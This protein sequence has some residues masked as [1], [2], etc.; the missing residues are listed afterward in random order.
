MMSPMKHTTE[1][2]IR[3]LE[4]RSWPKS[5]PPSQY[6]THFSGFEDEEWTVAE[7][8]N[9]LKTMG[10]REERH[11]RLIRKTITTIRTEEETEIAKS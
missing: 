7:A 5:G 4:I 2:S 8:S 9:Q 10:K 11:Y 1:E 3:I 6:Q